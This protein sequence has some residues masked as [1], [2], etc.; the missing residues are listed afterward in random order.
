M[1]QLESAR[2]G[3][4]TDEMRFVA[5]REDLE[6]ELIRD[7]VARG[8]IEAFDQ[9]NPQVPFVVRLDGTNDVEGRQL[10]GAG[11]VS[12]LLQQTAALLWASDE[13]KALLSRAEGAYAERR[14]ALVDALAG[15]GVAATGRS[16]LG[17]WVPLAEETAT[18][19]SLLELGWA[20]VSR[21]RVRGGHERR[22]GDA[23][24]ALAEVDRTQLLAA[25]GRPGD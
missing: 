22:R 13:T 23:P 18:T 14:T 15:H 4:I 10:L 16:G 9:I 11:W 6:P 5:A 8:L 2:A 1:T 24:A 17:V 12:H 3:I 19:Q 25:P 7:E 20:E 21:G